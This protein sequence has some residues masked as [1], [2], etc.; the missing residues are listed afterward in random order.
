MSPS[1]EQIDALVELQKLH[2]SFSPHE[3][4]QRIIQALFKHNIRSIFVQCGRKFGKTEI[5]TYILWRWAQYY[6]NS[7]CYYIT[8]HLN[9]GREIIWADP[10]LI[11]FGPREWLHDGPEGINNTEMR[12]K[13]KNGSFIKVDGSDNYEKHR[14]TRPSILVYEEY[15]DHRREFRE[16]MR[17][18][19]SV[20]NAPEIFI[21]TPPEDTGDESNNEFLKTAEEHKEAPG[22]LYYH[23][24]TWVN[25]HIPKQ[26]LTEEKER[27]YARGEGDVWEREYEAKYVK[28]GAHKI[29][30]MLSESMVVPHDRVLKEIERDKKKLEWFVWADPAGATCFAVLFAAL[31]PYTR[32][33]YMLDELYETSQANMTVRIIGE[34]LL[35]KKRELNDR[36]EWR[37]GY[38]EAATWFRNEMLAHF[39]EAFEPTQKSRIDKISGLSLIKDIILKDKL[40]ISSR[41]VKLYWEMDKY[42]K[43]ERGNIAKKDDHLLDNFRYILDASYYNLHE[44]EEFIKEKD[45]LWRGA[46]IEDDFPHM[47]EGGFINEWEP[48]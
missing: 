37:Q 13:F 10:R 18:N 39:D 12:I 34:A 16:V 31:N 5:A 27:L 42:R 36:Y 48:D 2:V 23:A 24:P 9:Q 35:K 29:F 15:K 19:L 17:P 38:D 8:P 46:R 45:P 22:K 11:N 32:K 30:P 33:W 25:P 1:K 41:C 40:V 14:G 7:S 43:D 4:Q 44:T 6:P 3:S 20:Y 21:G 47:N 28:G 26:W